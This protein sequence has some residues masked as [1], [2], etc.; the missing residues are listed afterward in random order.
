MTRGG[1]AALPMRKTPP[2]IPASAHGPTPRP[3]PGPTPPPEPEPMPLSEPV[4]F[5]GI[6]APDFGSPM[7]GMLFMAILIS[8]GTITVGS[9][10]NLGFM[11][12][13]TALGGANCGLRENFGK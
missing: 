4:P 6:T 10:G 8:G 3:S 1:V 13:I 12:R 2:P 7:F 9:T 11:L 5:D